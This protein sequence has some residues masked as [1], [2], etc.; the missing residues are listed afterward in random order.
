MED[1]KTENKASENL[2]LLYIDGYHICHQFFG[3]K[4]DG[5]CIF[6]RALIEDIASNEKSRK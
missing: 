5:E 3:Q 1:K 6:C 4:R 2:D